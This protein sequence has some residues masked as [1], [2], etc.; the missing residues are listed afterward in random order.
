MINMQQTEI[1]YN[2]NNLGDFLKGDFHTNS[3]Q[4]LIQGAVGQDK[5]D[6]E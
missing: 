5:L 4:D 2:E 3:I 6:H 1:Q